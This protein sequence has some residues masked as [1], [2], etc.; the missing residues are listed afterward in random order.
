MNI[1]GSVNNNSSLHFISSLKTRSMTKF[2]GSLASLDGPFAGAYLAE[3]MSISL[4][5]SGLFP[6]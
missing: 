3:N 4:L 1:S 6:D 5:S 2:P